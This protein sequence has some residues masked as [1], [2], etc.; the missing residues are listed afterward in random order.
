MMSIK[1]RPKKMS[2]RGPSGASKSTFFFG[3]VSSGL[4]SRNFAGF[5]V[6]STQYTM[7][8]T[9]YHTPISILI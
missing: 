4:G 8:M 9:L 5:Q 6:V 7:L 2:G 1:F 3:G